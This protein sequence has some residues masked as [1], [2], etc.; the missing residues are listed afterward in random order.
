MKVIDI[1]QAQTHPD[2]L[3]QLALQENEVTIVKDNKP[4]FKILRLTSQK[5]RRSKGSAKGSIEIAP[6][7]D[8]PLEEFQD[9]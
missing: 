9:Y 2:V 8:Q 4:I 3:F 1:E 7:F 5:K 6:D